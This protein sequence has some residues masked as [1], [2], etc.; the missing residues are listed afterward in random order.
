MSMATAYGVFTS[1]AQREAVALEAAIV[2]AT[3]G[4][5][6]SRSFSV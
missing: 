3:A 4:L 2:V 5:H 6:L 1:A